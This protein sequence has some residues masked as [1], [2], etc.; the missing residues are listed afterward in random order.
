M[1]FWCVADSYLPMSNVVNHYFL[2]G[3]GAAVIC[4]E[5]VSCVAFIINQ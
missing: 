1:S 3:E 5:K 2:G 4:D